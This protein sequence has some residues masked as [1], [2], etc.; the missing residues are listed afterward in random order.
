MRSHVIVD[1]KKRLL[2]FIRLR[3]FVYFSGKYR[4]AFWSTFAS[5]ISKKN[6]YL[7]R[8][9]SGLITISSIITSFVLLELSNILFLK[10]DAKERTLICK[11]SILDIGV[12]LFSYIELSVHYFI[13]PK[14]QHVTPFLILINILSLIPIAFFLFIWVKK[15]TQCLFVSNIFLSVC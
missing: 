12:L 14:L 15:E 13:R 11:T 7:T 5:D 10:N 3:V 2:G 9:T 8:I 6:F 4:R 1:H